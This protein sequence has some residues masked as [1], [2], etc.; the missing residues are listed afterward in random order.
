MR[1]TFVARR[2]WPAGG[3][4]ENYLRFL[5]DGL[6]P[7]ERVQVLSASIDHR[8]GLGFTEVLDH[9]AFPA[10]TRGQVTTEPLRVRDLRPRLRMLP[11]AAQPHFDWAPRGR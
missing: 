10:F 1:I 8:R 2:A 5:T 3:G 9:D 11:V 6:P 7:V 4:M